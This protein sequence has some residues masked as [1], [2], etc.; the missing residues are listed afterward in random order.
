[1]RFTFAAFA[2]TALAADAVVWSG[3]ESDLKISPENARLVIAH[4]LGL[5]AYHQLENADDNTLSI[6]NKHQ[7]PLFSEEHPS[8]KLLVIVEGV[9]NPGT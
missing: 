6:L 2:A 7:K 1:M 4:R 8:R 3:S 5:S 9:E